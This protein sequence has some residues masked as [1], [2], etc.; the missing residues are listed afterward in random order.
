[1][2]TTSTP[3]TAT[4]LAQYSALITLLVIMAVAA[5]SVHLQQQHARQARSATLQALLDTSLPT[6]QRAIQQ[7]N[8]EIYQQ[9]L[10]SLSQQPDIATLTLVDKSGNLLAHAGIIQPCTAAEAA[11]VQ[12]NHNASTE[13]TI[14]PL[15]TDSSY[16]VKLVVQAAVCS[17]PALHPQTI[18]SLFLLVSA[19]LLLALSLFILSYR[20]VLGPLRQLADTI[21]TGNNAS[22]DKSADELSLLN[23]GFKHLNDS[24]QEC[25]LQQQ[26]AEI[27]INDYAH[28]LEQLI[29]KRTEALSHLNRRLQQ[30][31][32]SGNNIPALQRRLS[33]LMQGLEPPLQELN[34]SLNELAENHPARQILQ[35]IQQLARILHH[36][37]SSASVLQQQFI[38]PG[39]LLTKLQQ[40]ADS[41]SMLPVSFICDIEGEIV[42]PEDCVLILLLGLL[43]NGLTT[44]GHSDLVLQIKPVNQ[45]LQI[46]ISGKDMQIS[47]QELQH[48]LLPLNTQSTLPPLGLRL[49]QDIAEIL[50]GSLELQPYDLHGQSIVCNLPLLYRRE[51][52]HE[53]SD[54]FCHQPLCLR[55]TDSAMQQQLQQWLQNWQ[56]PH[57]TSA[58]DEQHIVITDLQ[59]Y[60]HPAEL[61]L[62]LNYATPL[63]ETDV[64]LSLW[65][66][67]KHINS[68]GQPDL[69]VLL[70]DDNQINLMLCERYLRRLG[71]SPDVA[72]NG[73][74]AAELCRHKQYDLI[75]MDCLM[76]VMDGLQATRQIRQDSLNINTPI[77]ALTSLSGD[78]ERQNCL[79]AGMN[80]FISKPFN[81]EQIQAVLMQWIPAYGESTND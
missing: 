26:Q 62:S 43:A 52:Q 69:Q 17:Q 65:Q 81:L 34:E 11:A 8:T 29:H 27:T 33:Q 42:I 54:H 31:Q 7:Q 2:K 77:I 46:S 25:R 40:Q 60:G 30:T 16:P 39:K 21:A 78:D 5:L 28:K 18:T 70:T 79:A 74:Q 15:Q 13:L 24:L 66:M 1:M 58:T 6:L 9:L 3:R 19:L 51:L 49:L 10:E 63:S 36:I 44:R 53:L 12:N 50:H 72:S 47:E 73:L 41:D 76:P 37:Q 61:T 20:R 59:Y 45:Q 23:T 75:L 64:I 14:Y 48:V 68:I 55:I 71:I 67:I 80:D 35:Q 38:E 32:L 4:R 22:A 57:T 56:I